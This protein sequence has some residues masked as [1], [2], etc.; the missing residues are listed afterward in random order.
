[1]ANFKMYARTPVVAFGCN[2]LSLYTSDTITFI[3]T[4]TGFANTTKFI[5]NFGMACGLNPNGTPILDGC[6]DTTTGN[7]TILKTFTVPGTFKVSIKAIEAGIT[8]YDERIITVNQT[9]A[10]GCSFNPCNLVGNGG[11][12]DISACP[13][14]AENLGA[15]PYTFPPNPSA[16]CFWFYPTTGSPDLYIN[17]NGMGSCTQNTLLPNEPAPNGVGMAGFI[18]WQDGGNYREYIEQRLQ[19]ALQRN[20]TYHVSFWARLRSTSCA[21]SNLQVSF[22]HGPVADYQAFQTLALPV[23]SLTVTTATNVTQTWQL[24]DVIFTPTVDCLDHIIIGNIADDNDSILA[25]ANNTC[26]TT[27]GFVEALIDQVSVY[28]VNGLDAIITNACSNSPGSINLNEPCNTATT[29]FT[30][31]YTYNWSNGATTQDLTNVPAGFYQVLITSANGNILADGFTINNGNLPPVPILTGNHDACNVNHVVQV[32]NPNSSFVYSWTTDV[33]ISGFGTSCNIDFNN[34]TGNG[35]G[36]ITFIVTDPKSCCSNSATFIVAPCCHP[37]SGTAGVNLD[38]SNLSASTVMQNIGKYPG[39]VYYNGFG[40]GIELT[41][42]FNNNPGYQAAINGVFTVDVDLNFAQANIVLGLDARIN[43]INGATLSINE[44]SWLHTCDQQYMWDRIDVENGAKLHIAYNVLIEEAQLAVVINDAAEF[45]SQKNVT[46]NRNYKSIEFRGNYNSQHLKS[47]I[48]NTKFTS[49]NLTTNVLAPIGVPPYAAVRSH[50]GISATN[51]LDATTFIGLQ[52]GNYTINNPMGFTDV[53]PNIFNNLDLGIDA[54]NCDLAVYNC[55]FYNI[56]DDLNPTILKG[57]TGTAISSV[58]IKTLQPAKTTTIGGNFID[59]LT[60]PVT[61]MPNN[62]IDCKRGVFISETNATVAYNHFLRNTYTGI[63]FKNGAY[64]QVTADSN[65]FINCNRGIAAREMGNA[66]ILITRNYYNVD[67]NYAPANTLKFD[68]IAFSINNTV[69]GRVA[70]YMQGNNYCIGF[71]NCFALTNVDGYTI[72]FNNPILMDMNGPGSPYGIRILG[73]D[74]NRLYNNKIEYNGS[75]SSTSTL[76]RGISIETCANTLIFSNT[77]Q[78]LGTGLRFF[79][80]NAQQYIRCNNFDACYR[81]VELN[82]SYIGNQGHNKQPNP[83]PN[84]NQWFN[85]PSG[86]WDAIGIGNYTNSQW[87]FRNTA[88]NL[89]NAQSPIVTSGSEPLLI[90]FCTGTLPSSNCTPPLLHDEDIAMQLA[91]VATN[92]D[93]M[94]NLNF[95]MQYKAKVDAYITLF[96]NPNLKELGLNTDETLKLFYDSINGSNGGELIDIYFAMQANENDTAS[97]LLNYFLPENDIEQYAEIVNRAYLM[98]QEADK[99]VLDF[100]TATQNALNYIALLNPISGSIP[101]YQA[102]VLLDKTVND[103]FNGYSLRLGSSTVEKQEELKIYPNPTSGILIVPFSFG[104]EIN[105]VAI[106]NTMGK[107][108]VIADIKK[109]S[110]M[111]QLNV[112]NLSNGLYFIKA[113]FNDGSCL[114]TKLQLNK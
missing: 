55:N 45:T 85:Q 88:S 86:F 80:C 95:E 44:D 58:S 21:T 60:N 101:V 93:F 103:D 26:P 99:G 94:N 16:S 34:T 112:K 73:G 38:L 31:P 18:I 96:L 27:S 84:D 79:N 113:F 76:W 23:G 20:K 14:T 40:T 35:A 33:G 107:Q 65:D 24:F 59:P 2:K 67:N 52:I 3:N 17:A 77:M 22:T 39:F 56:N 72:A 43:V 100:D 15:G 97:Q 46:F 36:I 106:Y 105:S 71:K 82:S 108:C 32:D 30:P 8:Y 6:N 81:G 10:W 110:D 42:D 53:A 104:N 89:P 48:A 47:A 4:S 1:M 5:W 87:F 13:N 92:S 54:E 66:T 102:R 111:L 61:L 19:H 49:I 28:A 109:G 25:V 51:L 64:Y 50:I 29:T 98:Q 74:D 69:K 63:A 7:Q 70:G 78:K 37:F 57:I 12:E 41:T 75:N 83:E 114:S 68:R 90:N 9:M 11:F 91:V 62:F